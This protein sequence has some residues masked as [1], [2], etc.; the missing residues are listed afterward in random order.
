M[1]GVVVIVVPVEMPE[2][3]EWT[4]EMLKDKYSDQAAEAVSYTFGAWSAQNCEATVVP[5]AL[6]TDRLKATGR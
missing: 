5:V 4:L 1:Q 6:R 3:P 2:G